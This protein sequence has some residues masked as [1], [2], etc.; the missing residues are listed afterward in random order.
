MLEIID[1]QLCSLL[2]IYQRCGVRYRFFDAEQAGS[3]LTLHRAAV[4]SA[5]KA[6][7][8][9]SCGGDPAHMEAVVLEPSQLLYV[10]EILKNDKYGNTVYSCA[11]ENP[12]NGGRIP[13]W[14][15]FLEPP[16]RSG[17][18]PADFVRINSALFPHGTALL[19]VFEWSTDWS[20]YFDD[21]REWWG[22]GCWSVYDP[23][24]DRFTVIMASETD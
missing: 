1:E 24:L 19:E 18:K 12:N 10:P 4:I 21:G 20:D 16:C 3:D 15:A 7:N 8:G 23:Q 13:Y 6:E 17:Y 9:G 11:W 14:Y 5:V 22:T 2:N